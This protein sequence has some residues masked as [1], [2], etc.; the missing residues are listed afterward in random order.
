[1]STNPD[2]LHFV[3]WPVK[4]SLAFTTTRL[5]LNAGKPFNSKSSK[6]PYNDFNLGLHVGDE[7]NQVLAHR[8]QLAEQ[9]P[10]Q[11]N[12]QWFEQVHGN[13]VAI[14]NQHQQRPIIADAA[15]TQSPEIALAIMTADCLPILLINEEG[16]EIAAIHAGWRPLANNIIKNTIDKMESLSDKIYAWLGPCIGADAFEVGPE[17]VSAFT[18]LSPDLDKYF[19]KA[20]EGKYLADLHSIAEFL[21]LTQGVNKFSKLEHCTYER[22][23]EYFSYRRDGQTGRMASVIALTSKC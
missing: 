2:S 10:L 23:H 20:K 12:I 8:K 13:H 6:P 22:H 4:D 19:I 17:V 7:K 14:V 21:L 18:K 3:K 9:L 15:I 1:M 5:L 16:T 11:H